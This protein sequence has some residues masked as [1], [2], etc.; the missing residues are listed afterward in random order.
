MTNSTMIP[1][2]MYGPIHKI[3]YNYE[4]LVPI[5]ATS[6]LGAVTLGPIGISLGALGAIDVIAKHYE[7]YDKPYLT[8]SI[9]G[10]GLFSSFKA[11][12]YMSEIIGG[13]T[14]LL[15]QTGVIYPHLDKIIAPVSGAISGY[16]YMGPYGAAIGVVAGVIDEGMSLYN[17][18]HNYYLTDVL[19]NVAS[20][21][22]VLPQVSRVA[23]Y[24]L[25]D[26]LG[27]IKSIAL[28]LT[29]LFNKFSI[30]ESIAVG[31]SAMSA[32]SEEVEEKE[33]SP[34][35]ELSEDLYNLYGKIIPKKQLDDLIEKQAISLIVSKIIIAKLELK[36]TRLNQNVEDSFTN[37]VKIEE[38]WVKF[39]DALS[40]ISKYLIPY[41]GGH[42]TSGYINSYFQTRFLYLM[43]DQMND[44]LLTGEVSLHLKQDRI[45]NTVLNSEEILDSKV[46][47]EKMNGDIGAIVNDDLLPGVVSTVIS[48]GYA[49]GHLYS[50]NA[51]DMVIYSSIYNQLTSEITQL[52]SS[53]YYSYMDKLDDLSSKIGNKYD[54]V[55]INSASMITYDA[56]DFIKQA[57]EELIDKRRE[58]NAEQNLWGTANSLW[59]I[60]RGITDSLYNFLVVANEIY[61]GNLASDKRSEVIS[62]TGDFSSLVS[63]DAENSGEIIELRKSMDRIIELK[64]RMAEIEEPLERKPN[65]HYEESEQTGICLN[66]FKVG[67][68][69]E[70]RLYIEDLCVHDKRVAV[71]SASGA[72]KSTF[73]KAVKQITH[74]GVW[75]EGNITYF[76]NDGSYP[77]I[78]MTSQDVYIPPEDSL[79]ELIT[80][81]KGAE[82]EPYREKVVELLTRIKIDSVKEGEVSLIDSLDIKKDW[83]AETS[84]GQK[85]KIDAIRLMLKEDK[86][87]IIIFDEIFAGLDHNSIHNLQLMLDE[88]FPDAQIFII[89]HE[90]KGHN[91]D[92][93]YD[94]ELHM[95]DGTAQLLGSPGLD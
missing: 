2:K 26:A 3:I 38:S 53:S 73:F 88:E 28:G 21:N 5:V 46:L 1:V 64:A 34:V 89:D 51:L 48:G 49:I 10:W 54:H 82:A 83:V 56:N 94:N 62:M 22:L 29:N 57:R 86:P 72:G 50:I 91:A 36:L 58:L 23:N 35:F 84:G 66:Q 63:W 39:I 65:Y 11:P 31:I 24:I 68:G 95:S 47:I 9:L 55:K 4:S 13:T 15:L 42:I 6:G 90:A 69:G 71:T 17:I 25:P 19:S 79:L 14:G 44:E 74:D 70:S 77:Y 7:I 45:E 16:S 37:L 75:S 61:Q 93:W 30:K 12:Y 33:H 60:A 67:K 52:L 80:F 87:D 92:G 43:T 27:S 85:Q 40:V 20:C 32:L 76:T 78:A 8:S 18:T 59:S 81:K 41:V